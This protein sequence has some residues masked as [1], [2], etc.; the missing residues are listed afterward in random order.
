MYRLYMSV[1]P[2][3]EAFQ[4][5]RHLILENLTSTVFPD[6][7]VKAC[8]FGFGIIITSTLTTS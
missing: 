4:A 5:L 1:V 7:S 2:K 6:N 8:S 3:M